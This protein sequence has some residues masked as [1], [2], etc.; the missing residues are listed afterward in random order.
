M[1]K[2]PV[3]E[4]LKQGSSFVK[5]HNVDFQWFP[6]FA[7]VQKQKS[8]ESLHS[9]FKSLTGTETVL[10]ISSKSKNELGVLLSAFNLGM[11]TK[12]SKRKVSVESAFQGSK[13]FVHGGPYQDLYYET[14]RK[15]KKDSRLKDSGELVGFQFFGENWPT[16]PKTLFYDWIYLNALYRNKDLNEKILEFSAFTD[17]E[18][19]PDKSINCQAY[20]AA[21]YVSLANRGI[22]EKTLQS[23]SNYLRLLGIKNKYDK[24]ESDI[25]KS[26]Q[27][28]LPGFD[29]FES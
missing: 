5:T 25:P 19:N 4:V 14:S 6:G 27:L 22:L 12:K 20:S 8:I 9:S 28:S 21:L 24:W 11:T 13:K 17:I 15:A 16:E 7:V 2:R 23:R 1:A 18:F 29:E 3:Y 26:K 10:E